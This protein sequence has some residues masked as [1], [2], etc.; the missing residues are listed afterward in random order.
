MKTISEEQREQLYIRLLRSILVSY[1][2][3]SSGMISD[4]LCVELIDGLDRLNASRINHLVTSSDYIYDALRQ[5][6]VEEGMLG[7]EAETAGQSH[8]GH[9]DRSIEQVLE[10]HKTMGRDVP[11]EDLAS[12][13]AKSAEEGERPILLQDA[14]LGEPYEVLVK[15]GDGESQVYNALLEGLGAAQGLSFSSG[16]LLISGTPENTGNFVFQLSFLPAGA[17]HRHQRKVKLRVLPNMDSLPEQLALESAT[18]HEPYSAKIK[19]EKRD[20]FGFSMKGLNESGLEMDATSLVI[21]GTPAHAGRLE[22]RLEFKWRHP[23]GAVPG[24]LP[25]IINVKPDDRKFWKEIPPEPNQPYPKAVTDMQVREL[26]HG[27]RL[28]GGSLRGTENAHRG[29]HRND[30]FKIG[31]E[32]DTGWIVLSV[33]DGL[34]DAPYSRKGSQLACKVAEQVVLKRLAEA[35]AREEEALREVTE[36]KPGEALERFFQHTIITATYNAYRYIIRFADSE[37]HPPEGFDTT[38]RLLI[39][40]RLPGKQY[41]V[42]AI[43]LGDGITAL[44]QEESM[45]VS[46]L[47]SHAR[48]TEEGKRISLLNA[49]L[50]GDSRKLRQLVDWKLVSSISALFQ[51]TN[52]YTRAWFEPETPIDDPVV[53]QNIW[54]GISKFR[55]QAPDQQKENLQAMLAEL[56]EKEPDDKTLVVW[57]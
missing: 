54:A 23:E 28:I 21:S 12:R 47:G 46:L 3:I 49:E 25:V 34:G 18:A 35:E 44:Y 55:N 32:A 22:A 57:I 7:A 19:I 13:A 33:A 24:E 37:G 48:A 26:P 31:Y 53:W 14:L 2:E 1:G 17:L 43:G 11:F 29:L 30:D 8:A 45:K 36:N 52:G 56:R 6:L 41:F 42:A 15:P 50:L 27:R 38:F 39:T 9:Q 4:Q 10:E 5:Q 51:G 20:K 16:T 40:K